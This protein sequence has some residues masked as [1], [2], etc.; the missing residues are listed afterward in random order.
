MTWQE[1]ITNIIIPLI[2]AIVGGLLTL[3][4]V[5]I[6]IKNQNKK[7]KQDLYEQYRPY[8]GIVH[9]VS[10]QCCRNYKDIIRVDFCID[11]KECNEYMIH[12]YILTSDKN[13]FSFDSIEINGIVYKVH[14]STFAIKE[15]MYELYVVGKNIVNIE[16]AFLI[17]ID[18]INRKHKYKLFGEQKEGKTYFVRQCEE[19]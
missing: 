4:G 18:G 14:V 10:D 6:T 13:C 19:I 7:N 2:S 16:T 1:I 11:E 15:Q 9:D 17:L 3:I 8:F 12:M 5:I